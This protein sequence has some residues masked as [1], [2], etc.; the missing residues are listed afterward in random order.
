MKERKESRLRSFEEVKQEVMAKIGNE[1]KA[2]LLDQYL[3]D[4]RAKS[5]IKILKPNPIE[6]NSA[7]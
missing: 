3:K 7:L 5:F 2:K 6:G 4:L 1:R